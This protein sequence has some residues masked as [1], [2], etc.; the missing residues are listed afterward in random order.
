ME[1]LA[2]E[3][4]GKTKG[5]RELTLQIV[6]ALLTDGRGKISFEFF[7][8]HEILLPLFLCAHDDRY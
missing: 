5:T 4:K 2:Q 8:A 1:K 3:I 7:G 6:W